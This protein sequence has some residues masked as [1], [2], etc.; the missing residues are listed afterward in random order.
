MSI[1]LL[2][3]LFL[4][5]W[6][7]QAEKPGQP[8]R[9]V[10]EIRVV[11]V[12]IDAATR[13]TRDVTLEIHA[14]AEGDDGPPRPRPAEGHIDLKNAVVAR[15]NFDRWLFGEPRGRAPRRHLEEILLTRVRDAVRERGLT[16]EQRAKLEIA[17]R[18][19]IKRFLDQVEDRRRT[20]DSHRHDFRSGILVLTG[21]A[22]LS[23]DYQHGP[24]G[25]GSL[26]AKT[27]KKIDD[28]KVGDG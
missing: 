21:L 6:A 17:G 3:S 19:D 15:E 23:Q 9:P 11:R 13:E 16:A 28:K 10:R 18:G 27:L 7:Q 14:P 1:R 2:S 22:P 12:V 26:F 20:F 8:P 4:A 5:V 24:F 25:E